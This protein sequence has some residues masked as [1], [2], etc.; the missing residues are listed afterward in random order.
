MSALCYEIA[1]LLCQVLAEIPVGTNLGLFHLF[2][3]LLSGRFLTYRGALFP[4]LAD[5]GLPDEAVRRSE[6]ALA[7]GKWNLADLLTSWQKI[8]REQGRFRAHS[9]EGFRPVACDLIGFFRPRLQNCAGKHYTSRANKALPAIVV[10]IIATVGSIDKTRLAIPRALVR[11]KPQE[12]DVQLQRRLLVQLTTQLAPDQAAI[13]DGGFEIADVMAAQLK[14]FV[15]RGALNFTGRRNVLPPYKG[16]GA[17]PKYGAE[18]RPLARWYNAHAIEATPPDETARWKD[19]NYTIRAAIFNNLVLSSAKPGSPTFRCVVIYDPRYKNPLVLLTDLLVTAYALWR[20]YRD[21]LPVEQVPLSAKQI[22]G[23]ERAF[24]FDKESRLRLPEV[25]LLAGNILSY[26][27]ACHSPIATGFW[28]RCARPTCTPA[29]PSA[30]SWWVRSATSSARACVDRGCTR[31]RA[32]RWSRSR[33][34][35]RVCRCHS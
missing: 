25:A 17:R 13:L 27:A 32:C 30:G 15:L 1:A 18:V 21:R 24:V 19:G 31:S 8:V 5:L 20:L 35:G 4:S 7:Y 2:W 14:R 23:A 33:R 34:R 29:A 28:D 6:A 9:Y 26:V 12:T 10:G 11:Q 3:A 16:S 22:L